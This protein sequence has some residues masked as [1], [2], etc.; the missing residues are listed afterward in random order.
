MLSISEKED[1]P[2]AQVFKRLCDNLVAPE[3]D[4]FMWDE[5]REVRNMLC[6]VFVEDDGPSIDIDGLEV[7][8]DVRI[9][10]GV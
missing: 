1:V 8:S 3:K 2:V 9:Q 5:D 7:V 4:D 10:E 6:R